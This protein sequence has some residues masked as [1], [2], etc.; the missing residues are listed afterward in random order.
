MNGCIKWIAACMSSVWVLLVSMNGWAQGA[1]GDCPVVKVLD[2]QMT[3]SKLVKAALAVSL[4]DYFAVK[5]AEAGAFCVS[6]RPGVKEQITESRLDSWWGNFEDKTKIHPGGEMAPGLLLGVSVQETGGSCSIQGILWNLRQVVSAKGFEVK[7]LDCA[8]EGLKGGIEQ[9]AYSISGKEAVG[10]SA[11]KYDEPPIIPLG[12]IQAESD[13]AFSVENVGR[14]QIKDSVLSTYVGLT[15]IDDKKPLLR[16]PAGL[17]VISGE[18]WGMQ[19]FRQ[20]VKVESGKTA[21]VSVKMDKPMNRDIPKNTPEWVKKALRSAAPGQGSYRSINPVLA[22][23][24]ALTI[25][26]SNMT[27]ERNKKARTEI[28]QVSRSCDDGQGDWSKQF[29]VVDNGVK[30]GW[31]GSFGAVN[32]LSPESCK[33]SDTRTL[34]H[35]AREPRLSTRLNK[36]WRSPGGLTAVEVTGNRSSTVQNSE[37]TGVGN[38]ITFPGPENPCSARLAALVFNSLKSFVM[39]DGVDVA[40]MKTEYSSTNWDG[41][42]KSIDQNDTAASVIRFESTQKLFGLEFMLVGEFS[43]YQNWTEQET[44]GEGYE[45]LFHSRLTMSTTI[46]GTSFLIELV[47][48]VL[49]S[50][51]GTD[52]CNAFKLLSDGFKLSGYTVTVT[53]LPDTIFGTAASKV[54]LRKR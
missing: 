36:L 50:I 51:E 8:E 45:F 12:V 6:P 17:Y 25:A 19:P 1:T 33:A 29:H 44:V 37:S 2:V 38:V 5:L 13:Q 23:M 18:V 47:D 30:S 48:G 46:E 15:R 39:V 53:D 40:T 34:E 22:E 7:G 42:D 27:L 14:L 3:D 16:L 43:G 9:I 32:N 11:V 49:S 21:T 26:L 20:S 54:G 35:F 10:V 4:A 31:K 24:S 28:R 52:V 41:A